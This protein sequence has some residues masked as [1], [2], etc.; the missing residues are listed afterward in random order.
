[1]NPVK[2]FKQLVANTVFNSGASAFLQAIAGHRPE[3][4]PVTLKKNLQHIQKEAQE[5]IDI[6]DIA[7]KE[8]RNLTQEETKKVRDAYAD[9]RVLLDGAKQMATFP[10]EVD[11]KAV[12]ESLITRFDPTMEDAVKTQQKYEAI[13]VVTRIHHDV[14]TGMYV[15][16]VKGYLDAEPS[17]ELKE[18]YPVGKWLKSYKYQ[19]PQLI[20]AG[21]VAFPVTAT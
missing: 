3:N 20:D 8:V 12:L 10:W 18:E 5:G 9:V 7:I 19:E 1:V 16:I 4:H 15:N 13:N 11:Y 2:F 6:L 21:V 14:E 17:Q